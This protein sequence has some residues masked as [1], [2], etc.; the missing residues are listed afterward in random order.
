MALVVTLLSVARAARANGRYPAASLVAFDPGD[1][2]HFI[3]GATFGL[4]E[5]TDRGK[6]FR[7]S[8][9]SE[10]GV[11]GAQDLS[12]AI[13]ANRSTV[14]A[15]LDGVLTTP[16]GC[17]F[18][19]PP[20]LDHKSMGDLSSSRSA[21]HQVFGFYSLS[22]DDGGFDSRIVRSIDDGHSF[23][24]LGQ[25]LATDLY[26]LTIDVAPSDPMRVYL[27]ARLGSTGDY[28]SILMRSKDGGVTFESSDVPES[29]Q[30]DLAFIAAVHPLDP[31]RVYLRVY[32][33]LGTRVWMSD[34]GGV[35]FRKVFTGMDQIYGFAVAPV[36][37]EIALGGPGDGIWVGASDGT[38]LEHRS[39]V[40]PNCLG[41]SVDGLYACA[42]Q[43]LA[44]FSIGRSTDRGT[45]FETLLRFDGLCGYTGCGADTLAGMTCPADWELVSRTVDAT[46][47]TDAGAP[48]A[49]RDATLGVTDAPTDVDAP[50]PASDVA[51]AAGGGCAVRAVCPG[52]AEA[53][54][55][56]WLAALGFV[57][58]RR[59]ARR[60]LIRRSIP[61]RY[62][63]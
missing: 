37:D 11:S 20:E 38:G 39:D 25:P 36:G 46:C 48:D 43:K 51:E 30:H 60:H 10:L 26:P 53:N 55:A 3:V 47:G 9:E 54:R 31:D 29:A 44:A 15:K 18:Y 62:G 23:E 61:S 27:S 7:W 42:D 41:W 13:T 45:T 58:A 22:R 33:P 59:R 12:V 35:T 1:P 57:F 5:S 50:S 4:L 21:P 16:D 63:A 34:D 17:S 32:D 14:V 2:A 6:T 52:N 49:A 56:A 8:C 19:A 28:A 24:P 40:Q